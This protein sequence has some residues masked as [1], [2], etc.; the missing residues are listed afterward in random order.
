MAGKS[1]LS[2]TRNVFSN[3]KILAIA[4]TTS[5]FSL[6][7]QGWRPFWNLYLKTKLNAS[8]PVLG[9]LEMIQSSERLLFQLS[10]VLGLIGAGIFALGVK[11]PRRKAPSG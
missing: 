5:A 1:Y 9:L 3:R 10:M 8:I 4:L 7:E 2:I 6:V 11:E